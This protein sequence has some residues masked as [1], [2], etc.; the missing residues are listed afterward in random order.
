MRARPAPDHPGQDGAVALA[1]GAIQGRAALVE[2]AR[3]R[4]TSLRR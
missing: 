4:L 1:S 3:P 2:V